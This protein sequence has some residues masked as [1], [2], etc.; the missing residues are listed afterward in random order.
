MDIVQERLDFVKGKCCP[1]VTLN[2]KGLD[3][4]ARPVQAK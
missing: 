4:E 3:P 1:V 2:T